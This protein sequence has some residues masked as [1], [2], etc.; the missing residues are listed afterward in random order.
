MGFGRNLQTKR[1]DVRDWPRGQR[2][3]RHGCVSGSSDR[4]RTSSFAKFL[5]FIFFYAGDQAG[6]QYIWVYPQGK[7]VGLRPVPPEVWAS[8]QELEVAFNDIDPEVRSKALQS[9]VERKGKSALNLLNMAL[10]DSDD[11]VRSRALTTANNSN[12]EIAHDTLL[13][14]AQ[15]DPSP[16]V[17]FLALSLI[18]NYVEKP[19]AN[20]DI[21]GAANYALTDTDP[22]VRQL[23]SNL[24]DLI[25]AKTP[26]SRSNQ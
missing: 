24:I 25:D 9:L 22:E 4:T 1:N 23:A 10:E 14:L 7:G 20:F 6:P 8:T 15:N 3:T 17:R 21:L 19:P 2:T 5:G 13:S 12:L 16:H 18:S 11:Q 26:I